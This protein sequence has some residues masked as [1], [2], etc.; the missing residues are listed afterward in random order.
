[1]QEQG[2]NDAVAARVLEVN[3]KAAAEMAGNTT[4]VADD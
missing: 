4:A 3:D 2:L 1:M